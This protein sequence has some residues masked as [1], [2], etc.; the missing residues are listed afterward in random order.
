[1]SRIKLITLDLDNTLWDVDSII[2]KAEADMV[3]WLQDHVPG[4][5]AHYQGDALM[6]IRAQV[7]TEFQ[8]KN[9][10]LSFMRIQV[11]YEVIKRTG[12]TT[13][14]ARRHAQ[15]AFDVF[16]AGRNRVEFFPGALDMLD[17]LSGRFLIYALTNGNA[18]IEH[19]GLS[20]FVSGAYSSADVGVKKPH[21]NMFH[22]PLTE[23]ALE[24]AQA[25]HIGDNL[26]DD[27]QGAADVGM[28]S[29]W[30]NLTGHQRQPDDADPSREVADLHSVAAAVADISSA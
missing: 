16:F 11:L 1:M 22:A 13:S 27:I 6:D 3:H 15:S 19:T 26:V 20:D 10:D 9:H 30:V 29:V 4:S 7:F 21:P 23:L 24:P 28:H 18:D 25:I 2:V 8:H 5:L 14:E 17:A 12:V